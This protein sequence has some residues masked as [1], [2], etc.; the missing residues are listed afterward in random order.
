ML[1]EHQCEGWLEGYLLT[2][3]RAVQQLRGV[4]PN[5][6]LDV[7]PACQVAEGDFGTPLRRKIASLTIC[8]P[9]TFGSRIITA[10]RTKIPVHR[11]VVNKKP[12]SCESICRPT[13]LFAIG[14]RSLPAQPALVNVVVAGKHALP[15]WL[16]MD[17]ASCIAPRG[18]ASGNGPATTKTPSRTS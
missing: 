10:S 3:A 2:G 15:Q 7:Q 14:L 5:R 4:H 13:Q 17:A 16:T 9:H 8:S 11:H 12:I 1:S 18:L 6:R